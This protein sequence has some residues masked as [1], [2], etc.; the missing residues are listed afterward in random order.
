MHFSEHGTDRSGRTARW[1]GVGIYEWNGRRLTSSW[2][3]QDLAARERQLETGQPDVIDVASA[4]P[5]H[6]A[7]SAPASSETD[8]V[9]RGW[10]EGIWPGSRPDVVMTAGSV[11][12]LHHPDGIACRCIVTGGVVRDA[13]VVPADR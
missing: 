1:R 6:A 3:E 13:V 5:W 9:V 12:A 7:L 11:G 8:A 2:V 10:F 4:D